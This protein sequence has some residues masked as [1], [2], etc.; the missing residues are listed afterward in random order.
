MIQLLQSQLLYVGM[1]RSVKSALQT[2]GEKDVFTAFFFFFCV[3]SV[4]SF[5][6]FKK[7]K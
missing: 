7:L 3:L 1:T 2:H 5:F 6:F 4:F